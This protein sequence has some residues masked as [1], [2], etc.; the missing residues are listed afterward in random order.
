LV[1]TAGCNALLES[2][3]RTYSDRLVSIHEEPSLRALHETFMREQSIGLFGSVVLP[4]IFRAGD[5]LAA[6]RSDPPRD[7]SSH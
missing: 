6:D 7:G 5:E 2:T 3:S 1:I 4:D